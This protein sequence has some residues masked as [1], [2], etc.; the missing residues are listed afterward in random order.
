LLAGWLVTKNELRD[1]NLAVF[2]RAGSDVDCVP[3]SPVV[4]MS[5]YWNMLRCTAASASELPSEQQLT[6]LLDATSRACTAAVLRG[7]RVTGTQ[8]DGASR[9]ER[10]LRPAQELDAWRGHFATTPARVW[11]ATHPRA[12]RFHFGHADQASGRVWLYCGNNDWTNVRML[13]HELTHLAATDVSREDHEKHSL[14]FW[15]RND[16]AWYELVERH[17]D[18]V[19][20]LSA[21]EAEIVMR[22]AMLG[23]AHATN[24]RFGS[25]A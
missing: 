20:A 15:F 10:W 13:I 8:G 24:L 16:S 22:E 18:P 12:D 6:A 21:E 14:A 7:P 9:L 23:R 17:N 3:S 1:H 4:N 11:A 2:A 25:R 19:L 5:L